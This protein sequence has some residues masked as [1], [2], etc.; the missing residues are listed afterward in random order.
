MNHLTYIPTILILCFSIISHAQDAGNVLFHNGTVHTIQIQFTQN[1]WKDSLT[2]YKLMNDTAA[3]NKY[4]KGNITID[5][6]TLPDVGV[7]YKGNSSYN[8]PSDKKSFKIDLNEFVSGQKY[9]GLKAL[10]LN[11]GFKDPT[12]IREKLTL[13]FMLQ[14]GITAPR[15]TYADV[16]INNIPY[17]LYMLVEEVDDSPFLKNRFNNTTGNL[18]KGD[19]NG[20]LQ[21]FGNNAASYQTKYELKTNEDTNDWS[22]LIRL[23]NIINNTPGNGFFDSLEAVMQTNSY[24]KLRAANLLFVNLDSYDGSGHNYYIYQH[25]GKFHWIGWDMNEAF[26]NF[27]MNLSGDQ[28][29]CLDLFY[30][31]NPVT[32]RPLPN[33][34]F[35]LY[36]SYKTQYTDILYNWLNTTY[37]PN[38][39]NYYIDSLADMIRPYVYADPKKFYTNEQFET[40]LS[41]TIQTQGGPGGFEI[42]GLKSFYATRYTCIKNQLI[43]LGYAP[44]SISGE[45][46]QDE[47]FLY[48]NPVGECL[49]LNVKRSTDA[50]INIQDVSGRI[51]IQQEASSNR[52][53][54]DLLKPGYYV[55]TYSDATRNL[56]K[57][58]V[59]L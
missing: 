52:I 40:N 58:F 37:T 45:A 41:S 56:K 7:R 2:L 20:T 30:I 23:I 28:I 11:N 46:I 59:K 4:L 31:P 3:E 48:P 16:T 1:N 17:G 10:N 53:P 49:Y 51:I 29:Q 54:V 8:N 6:A 22:D 14:N 9:D 44:L 33:K 26:G 18:Y 35:Q 25:N 47:L 36:P 15:C 43:S 13:D 42:L 24:L 21:W 57:S 5:G 34:M 32:N 39:I 50:Y 12:F 55:L 19:P 27:K 38:Y